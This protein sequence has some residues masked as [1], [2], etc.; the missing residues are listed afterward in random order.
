MLRKREAYF[1][2]TSTCFV[3]SKVLL[4]SVAECIMVVLKRGVFRGL[5]VYI[6]VDGHRTVG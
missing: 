6:A 1:N 5:E 3:R 4:F 2:S